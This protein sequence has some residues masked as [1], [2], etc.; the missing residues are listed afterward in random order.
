MEGKE[1]INIENTSS[2]IDVLIKEI[3]KTNELMA[4]MAKDM[5]DMKVFMQVLC[6]KLANVF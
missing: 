4:D 3:E 6:N 1:D 5:K 2:K